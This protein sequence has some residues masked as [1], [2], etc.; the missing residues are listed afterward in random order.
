MLIPT[1]KTRAD[2]EASAVAALTAALLVPILPMQ[3]GLLAAIVFGMAWGA[4]R[5]VEKLPEEGMAG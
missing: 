2:V 4:F 5:H 3:T 1:L